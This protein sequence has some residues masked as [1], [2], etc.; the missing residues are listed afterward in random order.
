MIVVLGVCIFMN[1]YEGGLGYMVFMFYLFIYVMFKVLLFLG[2]GC[3]IYVVYSNEMSV[4]GGFYKFMFV[5]YWIF[6][7]V[8]L[9]ILGIWLF[10]G[11]FFKDE[12]L[13]V[14]F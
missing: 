10:L 12:I 14:C 5:I 4:M 11:F 1:F 7:I 3:I 8:C 13:I 2:V 6:L 9:V